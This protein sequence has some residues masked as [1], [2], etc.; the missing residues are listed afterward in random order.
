MEVYYQSKILG[1]KNKFLENAL[2]RQFS[3]PFLFEGSNC[4]LESL[5]IDL[6]LLVLLT[7]SFLKGSLWN[8]KLSLIRQRFFIK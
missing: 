1:L 6:T 4:E 3:L 8:Y 7:K 2:A 5:K